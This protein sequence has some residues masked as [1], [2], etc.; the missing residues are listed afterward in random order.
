MRVSSLVTAVVVAA[1]A[2]IF[3]THV[4]AGESSKAWQKVCENGTCN[5][6]HEKVD[7]RTG[8]NIYS[9]QV[10]I[11]EGSKRKVLII[12]LPR[13]IGTARGITTAVFT[14]AQWQRL[15]VK[16]PV[17]SNE[18][19]IFPLKFSTCD[20]SGCPAEAEATQLLIDE[21]K[22]GGGLVTGTYDKRGQ[23]V[24]YPAPLDGF[25][26]ALDGPPVDAGLYKYM[27]RVFIEG[28]RRQE[29]KTLPPPM[30]LNP[31]DPPPIV[32]YDGLILRK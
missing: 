7:F 27:R 23:R 18:L 5:T 25:A 20:E 22:T 13:D 24:A 28:M 30:S 26:E 3:K 21:M 11:V 31:N 6:L 1:A 19:R 4:V 17:P 32:G 8:G 12:T 10:R 16:Q 29:N 14:K 2:F 15:L 9:A